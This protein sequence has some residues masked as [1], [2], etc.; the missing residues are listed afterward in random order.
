MRGRAMDMNSSMEG[1]RV[2]EERQRKRMK[3]R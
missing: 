2:P 3:N 1:V